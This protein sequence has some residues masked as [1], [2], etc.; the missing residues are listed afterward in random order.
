MLRSAGIQTTLNFKGGE[1]RQVVNGQFV[2]TAAEREKLRM[3]NLIKSQ[4]AVFKQYYPEL[5]EKN[6]IKYP[7]EDKLITQMPELHG[8]MNLKSPPR[9]KRVLLEAE[10]FEN[11]LYLWEFFSNFSDYLSLPSFSLLELQAALN[12]THSD[13]QVHAAFRCDI[14]SSQEITN[15]PFQGYT[16]PQRCTINEIKENGFNLMNQLHAALV[17]AILA[18]LAALNNNAS[19]TD[20]ANAGGGGGGNTRGA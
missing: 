19:S 10:D 4:L 20:Q 12:F 11:L 2:L 17:S 1:Q 15:D 14:D 18:D 3:Q 8:Q 6:S 5:I 7:I 9:L 13:E 16:W